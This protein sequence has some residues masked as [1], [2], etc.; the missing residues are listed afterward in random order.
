MKPQ[1][2]MRSFK[3]I[4]LLLFSF[5]HLSSQDGQNLNEQINLILKFDTEIELGDQEG[6]QICVIDGDSTFFTKLGEIPGDS[7]LYFNLGSVSKV[8]TYHI[9]LRLAEK[10]I[11]NLNHAITQYLDLPDCY[12]TITIQ[13]LLNHRSGLPKQTFF[14]GQYD[15]EPFNPYKNITKED[16]I[17]NL[18]ENQQRFVKK[19]E[20]RYGHLNYAILELIIETATEKSFAYAV[21]E[22]SLAP[23]LSLSPLDTLLVQGHNKVDQKIE[24]WEFPSFASSEGIFANLESLVAFTKTL[25]PAYSLPYDAEKLNK[26]LSYSA[27]WYIYKE[28]RKEEMVVMTG[29]GSGHTAFIGFIPEKNKAVILLRNSAK[30]AQELG[31]YIL[32]MINRNNK[33]SVSVK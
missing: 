28:K 18:T 15:T 19:S 14:F 20:F 30:S 10:N 2:L 16:L 32:Q 24:S 17:K 31:F 8:F 3:S 25:L 26:E 23:N 5:T 21:E 27:P 13:D 11:L 12:N 29:G 6:I 9:V 4:I 22:F 33:L 7:T 1:D